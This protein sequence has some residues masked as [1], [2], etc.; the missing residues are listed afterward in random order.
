MTSLSPTD[1]DRSYQRKLFWWLSVANFFDGFDMI[2]LSQILPQI[3][4]EF[5]L[6]RAA[7]GWLFAVVNLGT[8]LAFFLI[9]KADKIGRKTLLQWSVGGYA[10]FT[11]LSPIQRCWLLCK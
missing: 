6:D 3:R 9:R 2:A 7:A 8:V 10:L 1:T 4:E 11:A 5:D